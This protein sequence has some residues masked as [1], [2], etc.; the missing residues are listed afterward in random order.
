MNTMIISLKKKVEKTQIW[1]NSPSNGSNVSFADVDW[2]GCW[3]EPPLI[4]EPLSHSIVRAYCIDCILIIKT[5]WY[6]LYRSTNTLRVQNCC[7]VGASALELGVYFFYH[8]DWLMHYPDHISNYTN[9][10]KINVHQSF[11]SLKKY[12]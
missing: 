7:F 12:C 8:F 4:L 5:I 3:W 11:S 1:I 2:S 6:Y 10:K 9:V